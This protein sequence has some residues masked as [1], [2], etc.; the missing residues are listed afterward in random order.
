MRSMSRI[1][2]TALLALTWS[3]LASAET[4]DANPSL[5]PGTI[6]SVIEMQLDDAFEKSSAL[7]NEEFLHDLAG[8]TTMDCQDSLARNAPETCVVT[9]AGASPVGMPAA[10]AQH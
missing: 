6:E 10:L 8:P 3:S 9:I 2:L 5:A 7:E 1:T 4:P